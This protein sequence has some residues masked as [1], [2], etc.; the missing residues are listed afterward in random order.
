MV[1][2]GQEGAMSMVNPTLWAKVNLWKWQAR[3]RYCLTSARLLLAIFRYHFLCFQHFGWRRAAIYLLET[4]EHLKAIA[5]ALFT[6]APP[7]KNPNS[8]AGDPR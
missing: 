3:A 6:H 8:T 7:P 1:I 4:P 2:C 5:L